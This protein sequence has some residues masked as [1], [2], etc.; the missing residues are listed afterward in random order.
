ME[1]IRMKGPAEAITL[2]NAFKEFTIHQAAKGIKD[3]TRKL[4][5]VRI[6]QGTGSQ[7]G[8]LFV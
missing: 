3:K 6:T 8:S 2:Q 5:G 4:T 7:I 1:K